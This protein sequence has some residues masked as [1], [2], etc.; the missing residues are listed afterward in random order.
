V[1][2]RDSL[3]DSTAKDNRYGEHPYTFILAMSLHLL[4]MWEEEPNNK[5]CS[6][7]RFVDGTSGWFHLQDLQSHIYEKRQTISD[8]NLN[9]IIQLII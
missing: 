1:K 2:T 8:L 7:V 9:K 3:S 4:K 5:T 6:T